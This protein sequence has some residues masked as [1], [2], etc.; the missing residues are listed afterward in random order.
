MEKTS[1]KIEKRIPIYHWKTGEVVRYLK[2]EDMS[3]ELAW[4]LEHNNVVKIELSPFNDLVYETLEGF[5]KHVLYPGSKGKN[6]D[7]GRFEIDRKMFEEIDCSWLKYAA[8]IAVNIGTY[9]IEEYKV[10][11]CVV[12][13]TLWEVT[14]KEHADRTVTIFLDDDEMTYSFRRIWPEERESRGIPGGI[15][16]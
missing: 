15:L 11:N 5:G 6:G 8:V 12:G 1:Y 16:I 13:N 10:F 3:A 2:E 4:E 9:W 7:L 14:D